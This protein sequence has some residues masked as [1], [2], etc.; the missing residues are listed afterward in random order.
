MLKAIVL[1]AADNV[2]TTL[3]D[4]A[5]GA[6]PVIVGPGAMPEQDLTVIEDIPFGHKFALTGIRKNEHIIKYGKIIGISTADIEKGGYVHVHNVAS[7][8]GRGDIA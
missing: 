4:I 3:C 2:A 8:R 7:L 6:A 5:K 1:Q